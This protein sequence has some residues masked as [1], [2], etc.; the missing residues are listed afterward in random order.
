MSQNT[1]WVIVGILAAFAIPALALAGFE[2]VRGLASNPP[3]KGISRPARAVNA[4]ELVGGIGVIAMAV[5]QAWWPFVV[6]G[7]GIT[8]LG[9]SAF[10]SRPSRQATFRSCGFLLL[11]AGI[12]FARFAQ[13]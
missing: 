13:A 4:A 12:L 7:V 1:L 10:T 6:A 5:M 11:V 2:R 8:L 9:A 3:G